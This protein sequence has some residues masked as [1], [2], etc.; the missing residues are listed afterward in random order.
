MKERARLSGGNDVLHR[1]L[2]DLAE[3]LRGP[4]G[5]VA[6]VDRAAGVRRAGLRAAGDPLSD[7]AGWLNSAV[8]H[9][10]GEARREATVGRLVVVAGQ[11]DLFEV[12]LATH[13]SGGFAHFLD[14]GEE[15]SDED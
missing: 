14:C 9:P 12:I 13:A 2:F 6:A 5:A 8:G 11:A 3:N 4:R 15:Q 10:T 1:V 7:R